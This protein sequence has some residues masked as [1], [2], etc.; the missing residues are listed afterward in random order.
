MKPAGKYFVVRLIAFLF[1]GGALGAL[2]C[3]IFALFFPG[4]YTLVAPQNEPALPFVMRLG[5]IGAIA[6]VLVGLYLAFD[7]PESPSQVTQ[8]RKPTFQASCG[9][10]RH[11]N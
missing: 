2:G 4:V 10:D 9:E 7:L 5:A 11:V 8:E 1:A 6:G 3:I